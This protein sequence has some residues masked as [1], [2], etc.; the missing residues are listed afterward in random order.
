M[1]V[2]V[3]DVAPCEKVVSVT[4][5]PETVKQEFEITY[6]EIAKVAKIP[7]FRPGKAPVHLVTARYQEEAREEVLKKLVSKTLHE[8]LE[9][10]KIDPLVNPE[11]RQLDFTGEKLSY[12]AHIEIRPQVKLGN[13]SGVQ[14]KKNPVEV[15]DAEIDEVIE[16]LRAAY[17][18]YV[19]V[20]D[21]GLE[22]GDF[23]IADLTV[24]V[25]GKTVETR[26]D[27]WIEVRENTFLPDFA[28]KLKGARPGEVKE[29]DVD[30]PKDYAKKEVAGRKGNFRIE[31][32]EI[33]RREL[34][35]LDADWAKEVGEYKSVEE[36][37]DAVR[38]DLEAEKS[39]QEE[40]RLK[41]EVIEAVLKASSL[42][43]PKGMVERRQNQLTEQAIR[44]MI[45]QGYKQEDALKEKDT[46]REKMRPEAEKQV[47][48]TFI[49]DEIAAKENIQ[50][51]EQELDAHF[52][53]IA[54]ESRQ[55][56]DKVIS[57]YQSENL[58][59]GLV[60]HILNQKVAQFVR[61]KAVVV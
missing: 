44:N 56:K 31:L 28:A 16:R 29:V 9:A 22:V 55:A 46:I 57:H 18:K 21:R 8:I 40:H 50:V 41:N 47:R 26:K 36:L 19:P 37:R 5:D 59:N 4:V 11:I 13:Y 20:E 52:D 30:F 60:L 6:R 34:R 24:T 1:K 17:A 23:L 45:Y 58:V 3:K 38:K 49:L 54:R 14:V 35:P 53:A 7:G 12:E 48:L 61:D 33:K 10:R 39:S 25:E 27:D 32:K 15:K 43:V 2:A 51:T 42:D